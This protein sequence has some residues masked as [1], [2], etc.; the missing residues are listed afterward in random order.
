MVVK[1]I[2]WKACHNGLPIRANF[3]LKNV[4]ESDICPICGLVTKELEGLF[5]LKPTFR[6]T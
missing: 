2:I 4:L 5:L 6:P 3:V 1:I